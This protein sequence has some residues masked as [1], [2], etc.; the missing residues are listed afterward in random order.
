MKLSFRRECLCNDLLY[1]C[2]KNHITY[3]FDYVNKIAVTSV[4]TPGKTAPGFWNTVCIVKKHLSDLKFDFKGQIGKSRRGF[5][6]SSKSESRVVPRSKGCPNH[7]L[8]SKKSSGSK[9]KLEGG[10]YVNYRVI[11]FVCGGNNMRG[12]NNSGEITPLH[13]FTSGERS[14]AVRASQC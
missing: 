9:F 13:K 2:A 7:L 3:T 14:K 12:P 10:S 5:M 4:H 11:Q 8:D 1:I 6:G